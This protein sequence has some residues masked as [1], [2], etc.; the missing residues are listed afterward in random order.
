MN[1]EFVKKIQSALKMVP[2]PRK[3]V[4]EFENREEALREA[5]LLYKNKILNQI[6]DNF[7]AEQ[8]E[9]IIN[10]VTTKEKLLMARSSIHAILSLREEIGKLSREYE[11]K[12]KKEK[13]DKFEVV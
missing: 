1:M 9:E 5:N 8:R 3:E 10:K 6:I 7:I 12:G 13:I 2:I 11:E 4:I